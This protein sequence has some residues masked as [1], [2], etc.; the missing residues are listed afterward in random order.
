MLRPFSRFCVRIGAIPPSIIQSISYQEQ[1]MR[2]IKFIRDTIIPAI[3]DNADAI[4]ELQQQMVTLQQYV[5]DYFENLDVQEEINNKLDDMADSG[6]LENIIAAY[7]QSNAILAF[8]TI[9]AMKNGDNIADGVYCRTY[10]ATSYNDGL[11]SL[12]KIRTVTSADNVDEKNLFAIVGSN[13]L[14]AEKIYQRKPYNS[15]KYLLIGDSLAWGYQGQD[16]DPIEGFYVKVVR[17]LGLN[18]TIVCYPGYGFQGNTNNLKW[19]DLVAAQNLKNKETYTDIILLGGD[20]DYP[21]DTL[22]SCIVENLNW[23]KA[24]F[25]NATIHIGQIGRQPFYASATA[26]ANRH[27]TNRIYEHQAIKNGCKYIKN[28]FNI[29]HNTKYFISDNVHLNEYGENQVAYCIEQYIVNGEIYDVTD[30]NA[31]YSDYQQDTI[32]WNSNI[33]PSTGFICTSYIEDN[34]LSFTLNGTLSFVENPTIGYTTDMVIGKL[35]QSYVMGSNYKMGLC[36]PIR[37]CIVDTS[38]VYHD[39]TVNLYN[40]YENNLHLQFYT[41][42]DATYINNLTIQRIQFNNYQIRLYGMSKYC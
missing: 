22:I 13:T 31:A 11:G 5:N 23:F 16:V 26:L 1:I 6:Q 41:F 18:A 4:E 40:D 37:C 42:Q 9:S 38:N 14:I 30:V 33:T 25:K 7:L 28:A 12:F 39:I 10:G 27:T 3:D 29:L 36:S 34:M 8:D 20:N 21:N 2:L 15:K 17:D 35:T 19:K 24:N 32:N